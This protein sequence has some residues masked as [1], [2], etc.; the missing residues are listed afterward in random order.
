[1]GRGRALSYCAPAPVSTATLAFSFHT[2]PSSSDKYAE[3]SDDNAHKTEAHFAR[4]DAVAWNENATVAAGATGATGAGATVADGPACSIEA[5]STVG[6][7]S[8]AKGSV[9]GGNES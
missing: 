7:F 8:P 5:A 9:R 6:V 4:A 2:T 3:V 1:M